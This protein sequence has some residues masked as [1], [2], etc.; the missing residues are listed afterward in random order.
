MG[1]FKKKS[2][3]PTQEERILETK[4]QLE[5]LKDKYADLLEGQRRVLRK[6]PTAREKELAE[7]KIRSGLCAYT[8]CT[9]ASKDLDE[10]TSEIELNNSL[11]TL[12]RSLKAVNRFGRKGAGPF[13]KRS[14]NRQTEKLKKR[15]DSVAPTEIFNDKTLGTVDEWLGSHWD[16]AAAKYISGGDL[17]EC[18]N[19]TRVLLESEPLPFMDEDLFGPEGNAQEPDGGGLSDLLRS[20]IF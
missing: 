15:E 13:T 6:N 14:I 18:L 9:Q 3:K 11:K 8:I 19:E 5:Q 1:F 16:G 4:V 2:E 17:Q 7:A 12:N 20:D 10:I